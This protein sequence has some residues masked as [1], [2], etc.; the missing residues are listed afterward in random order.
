MKGSFLIFIKIHPK[1]GIQIFFQVRVAT[2]G[3]SR[4]LWGTVGWKKCECGASATA[5][6]IVADATTLQISPFRGLKP[7]AKSSD[8]YAIIKQLKRL[9]HAERIDHP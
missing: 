6:S 2:D 1:Y 7:T 4:V 8:R 9:K 5:D 3:V